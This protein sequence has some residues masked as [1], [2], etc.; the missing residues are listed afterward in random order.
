LLTT[1][2]YESKSD[3]GGNVEKRLGGSFQAISKISRN[4]EKSHTFN[5]KK[6]MKIYLG[7]VETESK[8]STEI[9]QIGAKYG[10]NSYSKKFKIL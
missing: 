3:D 1:A 6:F 5:K 9:L 8:I 10:E 7:L 2:I 4:N